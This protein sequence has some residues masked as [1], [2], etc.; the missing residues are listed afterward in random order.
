MGEGVLLGLLREPVYRDKNVTIVMTAQRKVTG[1]T[2][3]VLLV[4]I[5]DYSKRIADVG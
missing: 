1:Y 5:V 4:D 2:A 3:R